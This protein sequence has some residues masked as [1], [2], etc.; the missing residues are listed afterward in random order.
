MG[1][2]PNYFRQVDFE[3]LFRDYPL[4]E[5]F[6]DGLYR[7]PRGKIQELQDER[8]ASLVRD[9]W[10]NPFYKRIWSDAGLKPG[11][12]KGLNDL[13]KLPVFTVYDFKDSIQRNP[14]FGE[15][16][17][18]TPADAA[19]IPLKIQS[20]GGT[21]GKPRPTFFGPV[22]WEVQ[23]IQTA[24]TLYIQ[25]ARPGDVLQIPVT[26]TYSNYAWCYYRAA[27]YYLGI[28][29]VT[30]GSGVVTSSRRQVEI[31]QEWGTN[32]WTAFPEYLLHLA[33]TA[34]EMGLDPK[35]FGTKLLT[36]YLGPD[37]DGLLRRQLEAAWGC[38]VFDNYGT[39]EIGVAAFECQERNG[40]HVHEDTL[41]VEVAD[42][43]TG[44]ILPPGSEGNLVATALHRRYPP[45]IR[46]NLMDRVRVLPETTCACG[47]SLLRLDHFLGRS[48]DMVKLRGTNLYPMACLNA[49]K[50]D[51]RC[52]GEWI[53]V[54]DRVGEG[55]GQRD[56]MVVKVEYRDGVEDLES[57]RRDLEESLRSDLG[58]R[59]GVELVPAGSLAPLTNYGG[60]GKVRRLLDRRPKK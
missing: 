54:V 2:L 4:P 16:Q 3:K 8:F 18:V 30:T 15:H 38:P 31:A 53:C 50:A 20:S 32:L 59:V 21:T 46:Y 47:S 22:E 17:G 36:S 57:L 25:G 37:T 51:E 60:E 9:A 56:E 39:H 43:D 34:Q 45:L 19:R 58:V 23:A 40:R 10:E 33:H 48:D 1:A 12:V 26:L 11:D 49:L 35:S 55:L 41:I 52:V 24:R 6:V 5:E 14:P 42:A 28:V 44:E 27:H 7:W 13:Q 29:P